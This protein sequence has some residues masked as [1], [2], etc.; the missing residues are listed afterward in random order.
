MK[1]KLIIYVLVTICFIC[2]TGQLSS[3][4]IFK[5]LS[6]KLSG[7]YGTMSVGDLNVF[8]DNRMALF[9]EYISMAQEYGIIASRTGEAPDLDKGMDILAEFMAHLTQHFVLSVG[10]G[11][12]QRKAE[13][14]VILL[15]QSPDDPGL[16]ESTTWRPKPKITTYPVLLTAYYFLPVQEKLNVYFNAG[17]GAY[18]GKQSWDGTMTFAGGGESATERETA[19]F[20]GTAFGFHGGIGAEYKLKP[21]IAIFIEG[22]ARA[23]TIGELKGD[24]VIDYFGGTLKN[25]GTIWYVEEEDSFFEQGIKTYEVDENKPDASWVMNVRKWRVSLS[26]LSGLIGIRISFGKI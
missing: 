22:K 13:G 16:S 19:S 6:L 1:R 25:S 17:V 11:Y 21:N 2:F 24:Q 12:L 4:D 26:G 18:F 5:E 9:D 15:L 3:M 20:R 23:A 14:E 8:F 7:G 10:F